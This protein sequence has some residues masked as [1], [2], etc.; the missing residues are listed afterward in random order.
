MRITSKKYLALL[1]HSLTWFGAPLVL[2]AQTFNANAPKNATDL[3]NNI[4]T[5]I[6]NPIIFLLFTATFVIFI[7]GLVQF[8]SNLDNEEARSTGG[9]HMLYGIIGMVIMVGVNAIIAIIQNTIAQ[10]GG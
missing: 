4:S 3:L 9:K 10:I 2:F 7:W 8:V 6:I 1:G 5:Y